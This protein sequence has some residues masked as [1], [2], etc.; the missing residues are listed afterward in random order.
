MDFISHVRRE[1]AGAIF[2]FV[3]RMPI[4]MMGGGAAVACA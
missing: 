4:S 2:H 1:R 3:T